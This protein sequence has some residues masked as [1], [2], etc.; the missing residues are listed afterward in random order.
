MKKIRCN[1]SMRWEREESFFI[2]ICLFEGLSQNKRV[3]K[4]EKQPNPSDL[5]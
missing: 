4:E 2:F 3:R 5:I 1:K